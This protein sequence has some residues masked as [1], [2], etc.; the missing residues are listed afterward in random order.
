M[1]YPLTLDVTQS[2]AFATFVESES[3][4][5][6]YKYGIGEIRMPQ[7]ETGASIP[8]GKK[9]SGWQLDGNASGKTIC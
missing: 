6:E 2:Y 7:L 3:I 8:D 5:T 9:F 4:S 1:E